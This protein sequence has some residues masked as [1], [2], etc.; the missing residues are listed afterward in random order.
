MYTIVTDTSANLPQPLLERLQVPVVP[1][2]YF[3]SGE[4]HTCVDTE[5]FDAA[6]Y[7]GAIRKGLTVT[8]SQVPP[9]RFVEVFTPILERGE[10]VL[11]I[12]M[13]SGISGSF[14]SAQMAAKQ[15]RE[16]YPER[17]ICLLDTLAASL[18][19]GIFVLEA[20]KAR[21]AGAGIGENMQALAQRVQK[22]CQIF[23]VDDLMHLKRTGRLSAGAAIIG[24][25]LGIK[26]LLKGNEEGR[27]VTVQKLRGRR[28]AIAAIAN[29]YEKLVQA[30]EKQTIGIAHADCREDAEQLARLLRA[31]RAPKEIL[32][33]DYEPVTG[34]HVGPGALAL[35]FFGTHR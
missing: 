15:L 24:T 28:A 27:I 8:T 1:F 25:A 9:Q 31:K 10:D 34:A 20:V 26:P 2:S 21:Q 3:Y 18:A 5:A 30:P 14:D 7:Y 16:A 4:E 19:E 29:E 11:F 12:S 35:F 22:M 33:V 17:K 23:T 6:G 32:L 13:S